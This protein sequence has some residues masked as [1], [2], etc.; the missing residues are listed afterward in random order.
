MAG[1]VLKFQSTPPRRGATRCSSD[2]RWVPQNFNPRPR[3]GGRRCGIAGAVQGIA[4]SI[5]APARGGDR[6]YFHSLFTCFY[7]NPRP[8]EGGRPG[9]RML[10]PWQDLFQSTPPRGGA[11]FCAPSPAP[12]P[13]HFNPRPREGGRPDVGDALVLA[14]V[15]SI[16]APARGGDH[17]H[18]RI[19]L[20]PL[21]SIHAP[22]RGGDDGQPC[23]E[24]LHNNISIHAPARGGDGANGGICDG[25]QISIHAPAR[26]GDRM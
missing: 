12:P 4:I 2:L 14:E 18:S 6:K 17:S 10:T 8:R 5:H 25:Q 26:G 22:A 24:T 7:F 3:E 13:N 15:I 16:H 9:S 1:V 23:Y 11:T 19:G 21:I 20:C